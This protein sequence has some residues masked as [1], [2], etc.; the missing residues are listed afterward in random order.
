MTG[1]ADWGS[2]VVLLFTV[3]LTLRTYERI[4]RLYDAFGPNHCGPFRP[5]DCGRAA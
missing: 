4:V 5:F 2:R 1:T 3:R